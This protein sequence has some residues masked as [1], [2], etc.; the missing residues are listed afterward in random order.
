LSTEQGSAWGER[1][2]PGKAH[3]PRHGPHRPDEFLHPGR[4][5]RAQ[6][7]LPRGPSR[8]AYVF[9]APW[10]H[11]GRIGAKRA[12]PELFPPT[13]ASPGEQGSHDP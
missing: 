12:A 4:S 1:P 6:A 8:P 2:W 10:S 7:R 9:P 3:G 13:V 5:P 11:P